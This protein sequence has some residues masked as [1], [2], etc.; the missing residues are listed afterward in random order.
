MMKTILR[1]K[2]GR[3][4]DVVRSVASV[5]GKPESRSRKETLKVEV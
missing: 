4:S 1:Q 3:D 2:F 5:E